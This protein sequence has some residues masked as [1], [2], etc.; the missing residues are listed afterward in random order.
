MRKPRLEVFEA[1]CAK[2]AELFG[3]RAHGGAGAR[4]G[5]GGGAGP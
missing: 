3:A 4:A 5:G 1:L 2:V